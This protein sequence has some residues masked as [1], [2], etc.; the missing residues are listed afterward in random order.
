M[1]GLERVLVSRLSNGG[2][3]ATQETFGNIWRHF[4]LSQLGEGVSRPGLVLNTL[5]R[6]DSP[7][8][9]ERCHLTS[10]VPGSRNPGS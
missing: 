7:H 1:S 6:Q 2:D 5:Q 4:G 3:F 8:Y 10:A 9:K